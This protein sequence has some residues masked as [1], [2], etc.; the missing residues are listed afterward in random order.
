MTN[1]SR[2]SLWISTNERGG[3]CLVVG[4][5]LRTAPQ[6]PPAPRV[7]ARPVGL[8]GSWLSSTMLIFL[9]SSWSELFFTLLHV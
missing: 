4:M 8:A 5:A 3:D 9:M 2:V 6:V 7:A 1:Q